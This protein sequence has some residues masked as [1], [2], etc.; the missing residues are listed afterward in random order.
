MKNVQY[1][2]LQLAR[3]VLYDQPVFNLGALSEYFGLSSKGAHRAEKDTENCG[4]VFIELVHEVA[5]YN[6]D[7]IS[8]IITFLNPFE[9][10]NKD[11]FINIGNLL[12][13]KGNLKTAIVTSEL[14]KPQNKNIFFHD[15]KTNISSTNSVDVFGE[16]GLLNQTFDSY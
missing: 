12:T 9:V 2:T 15:A 6:L 7:L 10:H 3:S 16:N 8:N 13:K 1:D 11:L 14:E 5:S 4:E